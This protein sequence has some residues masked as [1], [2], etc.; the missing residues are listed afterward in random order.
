L[1]KNAD[2]AMFRAKENGR[3]CF[4]FYKPEMSVSAMERLDLENSF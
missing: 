4:Q 3:H 2:T 1:L